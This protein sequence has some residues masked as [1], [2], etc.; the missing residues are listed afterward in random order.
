[1]KDLKKSNF[2]NNYLLSMGEILSRIPMIF[3]IGF[4]AKSVG[5]EAFGAWSLILVV[6]TLMTSIGGAGLASALIRFGPNAE[7]NIAYEYIIL[8]IKRSAIFL[9]IISIL[10]YFFYDN[11]GAFLNINPEYR[12]LLMATS[13]MT[14]GSI[15]DGH[16]DK[17]FKA[18]LLIYKQIT[19]VFSR[20]IAEVVAVISV[21]YLMNFSHASKAIFLYIVIVISIKLLIYPWLFI[22]KNAGIKNRIELDNKNTF[23]NFAYLLI[24]SILLAWLIVQIDRIILGWMLSPIELGIYA[25]SATLASYIVFI[26]YSI[27]PLFQSHSAIYYDKGEFQL[28]RNLFEIWQYIFLSVTTIIML[29][30]IFFSQEILFLTAG[31]EYSKMPHIL[32]LLCAAVSLDQFF[33]QYQIIFNLAKKPKY[34]TLV[35]AIKLIILAILIPIFVFFF[36]ID[37]AA[38]GIIASVLIVNLFRYKIATKLVEI[39][40]TLFLKITLISVISLLIVLSYLQ[41]YIFLSKPL[42]FIILTLSIGVFFFIGRKKLNYFRAKLL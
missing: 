40:L 22:Q 1:M 39:K 23:L 19:Y 10:V 6:Q 27:M 30:L 15:L 5:P 14:I 29:I 3:T 8:S 42:L 2:K 38:V 28:L 24:P 11:I 17:Y 32:I 7:K 20:T 26:S 12:W 9:G 18:R 37:G 16:L 34:S 4:L 21:F 33:T 41:N 31:L 36:G 13:I 35:H 25:F